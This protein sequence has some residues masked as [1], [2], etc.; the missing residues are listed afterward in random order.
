MQ[1]L[2]DPK[3]TKQTILAHTIQLLKDLTS[4]VSKLKDEYAMLSEES[5]E[6]NFYSACFQP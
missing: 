5:Q 4:Q 2:T 3:M 1:I 6:V